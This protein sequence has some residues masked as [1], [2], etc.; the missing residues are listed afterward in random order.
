[1]K[2]ICERCGGGFEGNDKAKTP[3][4]FCEPCRILRKNEV[5]Q[6]CYKQARRA[7]K[8]EAERKV[9]FVL[10]HDPSPDPLTVGMVIGKMEDEYMLQLKTYTP[11]TVLR[12]GGDK[13]KIKEHQGKLVRV[14]I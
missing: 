10:V 1:M 8:D 6:R 11:G 4:R 13:F 12:H 2:L 5:N 7:M 9:S 14:R 3:A